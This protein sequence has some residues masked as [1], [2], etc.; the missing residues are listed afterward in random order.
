M[1]TSDIKYNLSTDYERLFT[2]LKSGAMVIGFISMDIG[3]V[4]N[5]DY[6]QLVPMTYK[7]NW[8]A[9][10]LGFTFFEQD[11]DKMRFPDLCEKYNVRFIDIH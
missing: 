2:L 7:P 8:Q 9:F 11:F 10:D 1:L 5:H 3:G 4:L 6:S